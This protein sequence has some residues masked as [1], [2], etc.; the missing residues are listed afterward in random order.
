MYRREKRG[1]YT[2]AAMYMMKSMNRHFL[3]CKLLYIIMYME[4]GLEVQYENKT[5]DMYMY[6]YMLFR[7]EG[8]LT[9]TMYMNNHVYRNTFQMYRYTCMCFY[10]V[11]HVHVHVCACILYYMHVHI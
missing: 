2:T 11:R 3:S 10:I 9:C 8:A 5:T 7:W 1:R 4:T 6:M